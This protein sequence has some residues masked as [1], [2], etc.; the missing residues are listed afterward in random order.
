VKKFRKK[1]GKI[2]ESKLIY[3]E[4]T[5]DLVDKGCYI[6]VARGVVVGTRE[7]CICIIYIRRTFGRIESESCIRQSAW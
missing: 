2:E 4:K 6:V 1:V 7:N 5:V 3:I